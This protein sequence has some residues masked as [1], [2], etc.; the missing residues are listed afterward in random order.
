MHFFE[1]KK[2]HK[3][4]KLINKLNWKLNECERERRSDTQ[5]RGIQTN[6]LLAQQFTSSNKKGRKKEDKF[7]FRES[8]STVKEDI[9]VLHNLFRFKTDTKYWFKLSI[10]L[11]LFNI[12]FVFL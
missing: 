4:D 11:Y 8:F 5:N 1:K 7:Y 2:K 3:E 12:F 6:T 9:F 10:I